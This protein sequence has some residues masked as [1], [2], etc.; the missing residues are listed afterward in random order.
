MKKDKYI[1]FPSVAKAVYDFFL[2]EAAE[3]HLTISIVERTCCAVPPGDHSIVKLFSAGLS[4]TGA[5]SVG[6]LKATSSSID[7]FSSTTLMKSSK[8]TIYTT[9][10]FKSIV[11]GRKLRIVISISRSLRQMRIF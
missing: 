2:I 3:S 11:L 10:E 5:A 8:D 9:T 1:Y 7:I 6:L 4:F